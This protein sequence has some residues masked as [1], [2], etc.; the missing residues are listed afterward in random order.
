MCGMRGVLIAIV[1]AAS[2]CGH[3]PPAEAQAAPAGSAGSGESDTK[4]EG[5]SSEDM[6]ARPPPGPGAGAA[7]ANTH[8]PTPARRNDEYDK[9]ATE[10]S[11]KRAARQVKQ[12]CGQAKDDTGKAPGPWGKVLVSVVLGHNGHSKSATI[13]GPYDGKPAGKCAVQAFNNL[14]FPPWAGADTTVEWEVEIV[15]PS[16]DAK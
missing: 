16:G 11:L 8:A 15:Q 10:V 5:A 14:I 7:P 4:W 3:K 13:P 2:A 6:A 9:E 1:L 12:N